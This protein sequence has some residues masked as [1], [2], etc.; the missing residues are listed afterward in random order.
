MQLSL[1]SPS[2]FNSSP[3]KFFSPIS[4]VRSSTSEKR[5]LNCMLF[6]KPFYHANLQGFGGKKMATLNQTN[7]TKERDVFLRD[8][9]LDSSSDSSVRSIES[10]I[11]KS[12]S[13]FAFFSLHFFLLLDKLYVFHLSTLSFNLLLHP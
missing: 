10:A 12:V 9:S 4:F 11:N 2:I 3:Y 6:H 1:A 8:E 7:A 5:V 13:Y